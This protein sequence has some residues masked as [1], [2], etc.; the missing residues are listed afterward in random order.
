MFPH[1]AEPYTTGPPY[2]TNF[3][4]YAEVLGDGWEV[5]LDKIPDDATLVGP[6]RGKDRI[7]VWKRS[8]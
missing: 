7:V 4:S 1:V 8:I 5:V 6:H 3:D 2:Y